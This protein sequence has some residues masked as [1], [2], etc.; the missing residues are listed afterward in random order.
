LYVVAGW[1]ALSLLALLLIQPLLGVAR[2]ADRITARARSGL[3]PA[4]P[5]GVPSPQ[6]LGYSAVVLERLAEHG[7][8]VLG[9]EQAWI[10][11][12][13][14]RG[15]GLLTA[16]AAAGTHSSLIG[17]Q[18]SDAREL[19]GAASAPIPTA[20]GT[21]GS[22]CVGGPHEQRALEPGEEDL[23][24]QIGSLAAR[25]L[26]H[27]DQH[28]LSRG[29]SEPEISALVRAFAEA[30][31]E[32]YGH[33]LEVAATARQVAQGLELE[34]ADLVEVE[35]GAL[36][37]DVG[38]LH[39][40]PGLMR[41]PWTLDENEL[42]LVRMHPAWGAEMVASVPSLEPVALIV[43][44]HH[45][46]PDGRGYP[47]GL[48]GDRI[49]VASRIL[50]VCDAYRAMTKPRRFIPSRRPD[51]ALRELEAGAG[52]Q[53]DADVVEALGAFVREPVALPA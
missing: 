11:V 13:P 18:F 35:L 27:H 7:R 49:P 9:F 6:R 46:R 44:L 43:R 41:K 33:S 38:M 14:Q 34:P 17:Q 52:T 39:L 12:G 3:A 22:F 30:D 20:E 23:L 26:A 16:V 51:A 28:Q 32:S 47:H 21:H 8:R 10:L 29:D 37:H 40:P 1:L 42:E 15:E 19:G 4:S 24:R 45:E 2:R 48:S 36:L 50:A 5:A 31:G 53:F 25:V